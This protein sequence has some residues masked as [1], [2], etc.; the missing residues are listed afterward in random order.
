VFRGRTH[1]RNGPQ[2]FGPLFL[3][4]LFRAGIRGTVTP[5]VGGACRVIGTAEHA[6][7]DVIEVECLA[8]SDRFA[9]ARARLR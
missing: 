9:A 6:G 2:F 3:A 1:R 7:H 4:P 5:G 8:V